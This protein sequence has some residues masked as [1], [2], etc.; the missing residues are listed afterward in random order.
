M[1]KTLLGLF[2]LPVC[3]MLLAGCGAPPA[4]EISATTEALQPVE[5]TEIGAYSQETLKLAQE[6]MN[7]ALA[8]V[9]VQDEKFALTRDYKQSVAL[10]KS[11]KELVDRAKE[12]AL[13][14][15]VKAKAEAETAVAELPALLEEAS[16]LLAKAP[17]G[18]D[19][20]ADLEAMQNDLKLAQEAAA[21]AGD[22][23]ASEQYTVALGKAAAAKASASTIIEQV[24]NAL[25]KLG[26]RR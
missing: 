25:Q 23:M 4:E 9:K 1:N 18:K 5:T 15:K 26:R 8:E 3:A 2:L 13:A 17:K 10:L 14:N 22:A 7:K 20:K 16:A 19:T 21:E 11:T 6:E 12:E 24:Q